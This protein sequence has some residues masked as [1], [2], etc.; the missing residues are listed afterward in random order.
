[1]ETNSLC[2]EVYMEWTNPCRCFCSPP[3]CPT[4]PEFERKVLLTTVLC[5]SQRKFN[6]TDT[7]ELLQPYSLAS[8]FKPDGKIDQTVTGR[9]RGVGQG[10][11][12]DMQ[13]L[14]F[15]PCNMICYCLPFAGKASL[16]LCWARDLLG[17]KRQFK[18]QGKDL[19]LKLAQPLKPEQNH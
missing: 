2:V 10:A 19:L 4:G 8:G 1:M 16:V 6:R 11:E 12:L 9:L 14:L 15:L 7:W 17:S 5:P 18:S 3:C 13:I